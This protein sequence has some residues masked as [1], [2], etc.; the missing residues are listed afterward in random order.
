MEIVLTDATPVK[1]RYVEHL[2]QVWVLCW[3]GRDD[4]GSKTLQVIR[5]AS[6][7]LLHHTVHTEP[8]SDHFDMIQDVF[9]PPAQDLSHEWSHGYVTHQAQRGMFKLN[10]AKLK[11]AFTPSTLNA[12]NCEPSQAC[13]HSPSLRGTVYR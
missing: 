2:D 1:L 4:A 13:G 7:Q 6:E 8:V 9:L 11:Y 10:L 5:N 12:Y 3:R